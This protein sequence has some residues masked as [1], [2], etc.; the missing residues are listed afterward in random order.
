MEKPQIVLHSQKQADY[1]PFDIKWIPQSPRYLSI[2]QLPNGTGI[3]E[4]HS[5]QGSIQRVKITKLT[6]DN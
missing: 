4:I 2:G 5:L 1:T 3:I 6:L